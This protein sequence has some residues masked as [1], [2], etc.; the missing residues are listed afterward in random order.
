M[1]IFSGDS[2]EFNLKFTVFSRWLWYNSI[3]S[4]GMAG[5]DYKMVFD[6]QQRG[7]K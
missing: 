3:D 6:K 5:K 4:F 7:T 2:L 1:G